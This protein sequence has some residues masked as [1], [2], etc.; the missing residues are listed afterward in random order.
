MDIERKIELVAKR[1]T[2]EVV[3][4]ERLRELF[5]TVERPKHYLG[6]E[7]SGFAHIGYLSL[8]IKI[9]DFME[10]GIRPTLFFADYHSWINKKLGGDIELIRRVALGY[11]KHVFV[12][13]G[14]EEEKAEFILASSIYDKDYWKRALEIANNTTLSRVMRSITIMGRKESMNIPSSF[15][16]YPIMQA[17]DIFE[18]DVD[19]AHAGMDQRKVHMLAIDVADKLALKKPVAVHNH[20]IPSLQGMDRMNPEETKMSKSKPD[21][22]LFLHESEEEIRRKVKKAYCPEGVVD[23][24]PVIDVV[25]W[26]I[27]RNDDDVLNIERPDK[28]GGNL[29]LTLNELKETYSQKKLHPLDLKNAVADWFVETLKPVR[30]YFERHR[31]LIEEMERARITR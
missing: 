30:S 1:P 24:N 23:N 17:A 31:E 16:F 9:R 15:I 18:L 27:L 21:S 13:M 2:E 4:V 12:A 5:E 28:F 19:I 22:A 6:F 25:E 11:F 8:A 3:T 14:I 10:A 29:T 7:I 20:L 26:L